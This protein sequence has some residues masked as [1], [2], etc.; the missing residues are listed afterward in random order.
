MPGA[1]A[2]SGDAGTGT[3][4]DLSGKVGIYLRHLFQ[5]APGGSRSRVLARLPLVAVAL[6]VAWN[7]WGLRS[8]TLP[9]TYLND[10][11]VHAQMVRFATKTIE[12]WAGRLL[13]PGSPISGWGRRSTCATRAWGRFLAGLV[14]TVFGAGHF[15]LV[16]IPAP[17]GVAFCRL[18]LGP[19]FGLSAGWP[20]PHALCSSW[21]PIRHRLRAGRLQ[22]DRRA[23][24]RTQLLASWACR[25]P[26]PHVASHAGR[27][28]RLAG[29]GP[30]G[31]DRGADP[32][33]ATRAAGRD[34]VHRRGAGAAAPPAGPGALVFAGSLLTA[35]W[36]IVPIL[37]FAA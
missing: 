10:A 34:G 13:H 28:V 3:G 18:C 32:R 33:A 8:V 29:V 31:P 16:H 22:L 37:V 1:G 14:G 11:A 15:P 26:G 35:A 7:L 27:P 30:G 5:P 24:V 25:S 6:V 2:A 19:D 20:W 21:S 4:G 17:V 23:A 9:V 12:A 36:A